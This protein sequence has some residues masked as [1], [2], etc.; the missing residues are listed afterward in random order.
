M[1]KRLINSI[2]PIPC[3]LGGS[4]LY[5]A[6]INRP[7]PNDL[8]RCGFLFRHGE[9]KGKQCGLISSDNSGFCSYCKL[10]R[11]P[12]TNILSESILANN[13]Q[14]VSQCLSNS[15]NDK[16]H[17]ILKLTVIDNPKSVI[18][19]DIIPTFLSHP[20]Y[21]PEAFGYEILR[22]QIFENIPSLILS[23]FFHKRFLMKSVILECTVEFK[24]LISQILDPG[25][26][27]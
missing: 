16:I 4:I 14:V 11:S 19:P 24:D 5:K 20:K 12:S 27:L 13:H 22:G 1:S 21:F 23:R 7:I 25:I 6:S 18:S 26:K 10:T 2:A 15:R 17:E 3:K 8:S 9:L